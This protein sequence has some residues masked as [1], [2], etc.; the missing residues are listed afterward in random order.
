MVRR[1]LF[2]IIVLGLI[3]RVGYTVA[4]YEKSL[5]S[6]HYGDW[7]EYA[8]AAEQIA[9][10]DLSFSSS[11][12]LVRPPLF[13]L[14]AAALDLRPVL[15]ITINIIIAICIIPATYTLAR[16]CG[17]SRNL[18][19]LAALILAL[20][21]TS[22]KYSGVMLAEPLANLWLALAFVSLAALRRAESAK[23]IVIIGGDIHS[24]VRSYATRVI[25][26]LASDGNLDCGGPQASK[27]ISGGGNYRTGSFGG[28]RLEIPQRHLFQQQRVFFD[29]RL[30]PAVLSRRY[31]ALLGA[32]A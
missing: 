10:G 12:F 20:D 11:Y 16:L 23:S 9:S 29:R 25:S 2:A 8:L 31:G 28:W 30:Q 22:I 4:I 18:S 21:P 6:Y 32:W 5:L 13:P 17:L 14:L 24:S 19:L 15:I 1:K 27:I 26:A 7:T 3:L